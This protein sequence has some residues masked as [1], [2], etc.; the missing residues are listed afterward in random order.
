MILT[1]PKLYARV[2]SFSS[3][4]TTLAMAAKWEWPIYQLDVVA[5]FLYADIKEE[6]YMSLLEGFKEFDSNGMELFGRLQ[7]A[8]YVTKE[9]AYEWRS[10]F[11]KFL[12]EIVYN[13]TSINRLLS[14]GPPV[15]RH[16]FVDLCRSRP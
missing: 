13:N 16:L 5:A 15:Q 4:Q 1:I 2:V 9:A 11:D 7:K 3:V 8:L 14:V 12:I 10:K 6:L